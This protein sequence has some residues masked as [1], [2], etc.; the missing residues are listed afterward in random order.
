MTS[1][2]KWYASDT[3]QD[4]LHDMYQDIERFIQTTPEIEFDYETETL[5]PKF[6]RFIYNVYQ[7]H[8]KELFEPYDQD[9]YDYFTMKFSSDLVDMFMRWRYLS[10]LYN[11]S[12]FHYVADTS[13]DLEYFLFNHILVQEPYNDEKQENNIEDSIDESDV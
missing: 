2:D 9:M 8:K 11:L 10:T 12:L 7:V 1:F 4:I 3:I 5:Y 6:V 13:I